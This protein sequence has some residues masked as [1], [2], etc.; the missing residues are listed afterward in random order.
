MSEET[1]VFE[2]AQIK[3]ADQ[4]TDP[5]TVTIE[6]N[7]INGKRQGAGEA[8]LTDEVFSAIEGVNGAAHVHTSKGETFAI[9]IR[10][11][12][13]QSGRVEFVTSGP[14]PEA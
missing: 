4:T 3:I 13:K 7:R 1:R 8:K 12:Y 14:V 10:K 5:M 6:V 11:A 9:M 2:N